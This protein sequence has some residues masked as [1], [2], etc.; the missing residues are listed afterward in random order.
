MQNLKDPITSVGGWEE[1]EEPQTAGKPP[2]QGP[3][4]DE[5]LPQAHRAAGS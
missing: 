1:E 5:G 3:R 4:Q 2:P